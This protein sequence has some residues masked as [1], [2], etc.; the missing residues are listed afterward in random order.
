MKFRLVENRIELNEGPRGQTEAKKLA[1]AIVYYF[2]GV[3]LN[4]DEWM[5]HHVDGNHE[6]YTPSNLCLIRKSSTHGSSYH[7]YEHSGK[8]F[9]SEYKIMLKEFFP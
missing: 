7:N 8:E 1:C 3:E 9:P 6:N 5:L 4:P 2:T